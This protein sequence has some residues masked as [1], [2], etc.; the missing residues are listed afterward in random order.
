V[1]GLKER[2]GGVARGLGG[3]GCPRVQGAPGAWVKV[4]GSRGEAGGKPGALGARG[5]GAGWSWVEVGWSLGGAGAILRPGGGG[6]GPGVQGAWVEAGEGRRKPGGS[7]VQ[8]ALGEAGG[9]QV[10]GGVELL[11]VGGGG[12][13]P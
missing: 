6:V 10:Q 1:F 4:G 5:G 3:P 11:K 9:S 2:C 12:G 7:R 8:G 13:N